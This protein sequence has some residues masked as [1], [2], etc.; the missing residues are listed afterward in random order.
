MN[1]NNLNNHPFL[2]SGSTGATPFFKKNNMNRL[3]K[4]SGVA[5][6]VTLIISACS[7]KSESTEQEEV[8]GI[9]NSDSIAIIEKTNEIM[10]LL[11]QHDIT[12]A[13]ER[14]YVFNPVDSTVAH[15]SEEEIKNLNMRD[16]VF[17]V[18]QYEVIETDFREPLYNA[19]VYDVTFGAPDPETGLA[20]KTKM[21][22]NIINIDGNMHVTS[23]D[24]NSLPQ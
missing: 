8:Y 15:V 3:L 2:G 4:L 1:N 22:F 16:K 17:P 13:A 9:S 21:A 12:T 6:S 20:P 23:M 18:V 5:L 10:T 24:K 14:L 19:V 11:Q 7:R